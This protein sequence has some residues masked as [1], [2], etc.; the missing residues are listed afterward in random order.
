MILLRLAGGLGNQIFQLGAALLLTKKIGLRKIVIDDSSLKSYKTK[1]QNELLN[2]FDFSKLDLEFQ[3]KKVFLTK[4]R[5]PRLLTLKIPGYPFV[6]DKNFQNALKSPNHFFIF[7]DGYF[8]SCLTQENFDEEVKIIKSILLPYKIQVKDGCVIHI[9]GSDFTEIGWN[10]VTPKEYYVKAIEIMK[11]EY[12]QKKFY[13]ITDDKVYA[14]SILNNI[15]FD[16]QFIGNNIIDDFRLIGSFKY[17][18]ISSS[19]FALWASA[20]GKNEKSIVIAPAYWSPKSERKIYL[21]NE[22]RIIYE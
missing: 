20:L 9:R 13:I 19:T 15:D 10:K 8:Q 21:P 11:S 1:R 2:F 14:K 17:R 3:F 12:R 22:K 7:L 16:Y 4:L 6:S 5:I 18:I